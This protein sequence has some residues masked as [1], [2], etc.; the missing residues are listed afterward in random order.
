M[1]ETSDKGR[2][3]YKCAGGCG[4]AMIIFLP[5]EAPCIEAKFAAHAR[6]WRNLEIMNGELCPMCAVT[7]PEPNPDDIGIFQRRCEQD[8][9]FASERVYVTNAAEASVEFYR[10]G[11][12]KVDGKWRCPACEKRE[13]ET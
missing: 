13:E 4:T 3:L 11:W 9:C 5:P 8:G 6:G 10:L 12:C 7:P 2:Y 1:S